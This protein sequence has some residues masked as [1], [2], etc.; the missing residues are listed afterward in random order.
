MVECESRI[1]L[2][3]KDKILVLPRYELR[4]ERNGIDRISTPTKRTGLIYEDYCFNQLLE[5]YPQDFI[6]GPRLIDYLGDVCH[7]SLFKST[8][9][10]RPDALALSTYMGTTFLSAIVECKSGND[11]EL[12]PKAKG[13][14]DLVKAIE[15]N[16]GEIYKEL[17]MSIGDEVNRLPIYPRN[18]SILEDKLKVV[19]MTNYDVDEIV[20]NYPVLEFE[21]VTFPLPTLLKAS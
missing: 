20:G 18:I 16:P 1:I 6:F 19:F 3:K 17:K 13:F 14:Q 15:Q 4:I 10:T 11:P 12:R 2:P 7:S 8:G 9:R 5:T 21:Y